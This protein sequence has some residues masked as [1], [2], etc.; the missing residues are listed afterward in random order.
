[1]TLSE[2]NRPE[3]MYRKG[4]SVDPEFEPSEDLYYRCQSQHVAESRLLPTA[5]RFPDFSVNRAKYSLPEDVLIPDYQTWGIAAFKVEDI[6]SGRTSDINTTYTWQVVHDP[7]EDNYAHS[8]VRTY[9]NKY[10]AKNL[11]VSKIIKKE[12][13]QIVSDRARIIK[14]PE[15]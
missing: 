2:D 12:F 11:D 9:K 13:R 7:N 4:R 3:R 1:V 5:L 15:V 6:P 14:Q 8:E 10:Y